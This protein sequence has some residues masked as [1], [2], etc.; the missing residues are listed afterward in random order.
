MKN[1][2]GTAPVPEFAPILTRPSR[3]VRYGDAPELVRSYL[4]ARQGMPLPPVKMHALGTAPKVT[5]VPPLHDTVPDMLLHELAGVLLYDG[6]L[7]SRQGGFFPDSVRTFDKNHICKFY[8]GP[9]SQ[10]EHLGKNYFVPD[11]P[12]G[13]EDIADPDTIF[14]PCFTSHMVYGHWLLEAA[15]GLWALPYV[16]A[17][18]KGAPVKLLLSPVSHVPKYMKQFGAMLGITEHDYYFPS[19]CMRLKKLFMPSKAYMHM[20]YVSSFAR[21]MWAAIGEYHKDKATLQMGQMGQTGQ[22][23][24][25]PDKLYIS[26]RR[27]KK[28][29]MENEE[30]CEALF[31]RRGF[32]V[33]HPQEL[34]L[35]DQIMLFA[36]ATHVA[37]PVG[38]A[39]HNVVFSSHPEKLKTLF[40]G[41][42]DYTSFKAIAV[43]EQA[44][45]RPANFVFGQPR[46]EER[47]SWRLPIKELEAAL[48]QW[49]AQ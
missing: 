1:I 5:T 41:P 6:I 46:T 48:E 4:I 12:A 27:V 33:V 39:V 15:S 37:G 49:L 38:S 35:A 3:M 20:A 36:N 42:D 40:F 32:T 26:R 16:R 17:L 24:S 19:K 47:R 2:Q 13:C 44:Y 34:P 11:D 22:T 14:L 23:G 21:Q 7:Y 29:R 31:I 45:G 25:T 10:L 8:Y 43:L 18:A 9:T 28:R 30:E